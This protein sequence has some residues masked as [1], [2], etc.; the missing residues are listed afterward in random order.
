M[1]YDKST[2]YNK[3]VRDFL[4]KMDY[5]VDAN[6]ACVSKPLAPLDDTASLMVNATK[7]PAT[8]NLGLGAGA[9][10]VVEY[11][12]PM[13]GYNESVMGVQETGGHAYPVYYRDG[14]Y[15][16]DLVL[17]YNLTMGISHPDMWKLP[18]DCPSQ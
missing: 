1:L 4:K 14:R 13:P 6:G 16:D 2:G 3:L 5:V 7:R 12:F 18:D 15:M 9:I 17:Y 10:N 11:A 8:V